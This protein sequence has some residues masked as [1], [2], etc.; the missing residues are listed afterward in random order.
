MWQKKC[1]R[2]YTHFLVSFSMLLLFE[3]SNA[4]F[5]WTVMFF[6]LPFSLKKIPNLQ[7]TFCLFKWSATRL[8][9]YPFIYIRK[10]LAKEHIKSVRS[11]TF[12]GCEFTPPSDITT[13]TRASGRCFTPSFPLCEPK[14]CSGKENFSP[15]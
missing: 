4:Y 15:E 13:I 6:F 9:S 12:I 3:Y 1:H 8:K 10:T 11:E 5:K 7:T 2:R 14:R